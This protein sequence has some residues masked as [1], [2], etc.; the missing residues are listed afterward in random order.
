MKKEIFSSKDILDN[1]LYEPVMRDINKLHISR[2]C[3]AP[4]KGI[5]VERNYINPWFAD[6][7]GDWEGHEEKICLL[8]NDWNDSVLTGIN[9]GQYGSYYESPEFQTFANEAYDLVMEFNADIAFDRLCGNGPY[10]MERYFD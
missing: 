2:G 3:P 6:G 9:R 4:P 10:F 5:G 7:I 1:W 8:A